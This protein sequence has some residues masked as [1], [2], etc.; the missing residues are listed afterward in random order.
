MATSIIRNSDFVSVLRGLKK[1]D[2]YNAEVIDW[3]NPEVVVTGKASVQ[4]FLGTEDDTDRQTTTEGARL[5][6][7][8]P[9]ILYVIEPTDRIL[10]DGFTYEIDSHPQVW[11]LFGRPH[12]L[13][14]NLRRVVG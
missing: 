10:Y 12:H 2:E 13:E 6:S 7:D 8:D 3:S 11:R 9:A 5:I 4:N 1:R 14:V